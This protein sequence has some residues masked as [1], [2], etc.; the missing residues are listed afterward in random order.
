MSTKCSLCI[1]PIK[2]EDNMAFVQRYYPK[3]RN[4][5]LYYIEL[6]SEKG[7]CLECIDEDKAFSCRRCLNIKLIKH[8][9][10]YSCVDCK[11][12]EGV[13]Y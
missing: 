9:D 3:L 1:K 10:E 6:P 11:D 8:L 12:M 7:I 5:Y 4:L 13:I 2:E